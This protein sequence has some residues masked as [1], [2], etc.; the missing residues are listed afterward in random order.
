MK[1][2]FIL[3]LLGL[4]YSSLGWSGDDIEDNS[5]LVEEAYNQD[6]GVM[7]FIFT[8]QA[9]NKS[10]DTNFSFTNEMPLGSQTHQ[11]SYSIPYNHLDATGINGLGDVQLN[12]RY[13]LL[14]E[15]KIAMAPRLSLILPTGDYK[16][17]LGTN[18]V[19]LQFNHTLSVQINPRLMNHWN[20]G[21][22]YT[23]TYKEPSVN[24]TDSTLSFNFATSFV[25]LC[26]KTFNLMAEF[27]GNQNETLAEPGK[28]AIANTFFFV[29]GFRYAINFDSGLQ[30]VPGLGAPI[31]FGPSER[32]SAVFVYLSVEN[33]FW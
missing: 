18:S 24:A 21:F 9:F 23:P 22:T 31:G 19:G 29:P 3:I 8:Y 32:E 27:V 28:K 13:Q 7:Q 16:K 1:K 4:T 25:Y 17:G 15:E 33:K 10:K 14:A 5:F 6:P 26:S 30:I 12:Y 2:T 20:M 11:F